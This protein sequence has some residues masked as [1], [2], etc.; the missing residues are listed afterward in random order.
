MIHRA[1]SLPGLGKGLNPLRG[2]QG[3]PQ[4]LF[5]AEEGEAE[6]IFYSLASAS[7]T[8]DAFQIYGKDLTRRSSHAGAYLTWLIYR[9]QFPQ[10]RKGPK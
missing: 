10:V 3:A 9:G 5:S 7:V 8:K 1:Q 6:Q 4:P 2:Y